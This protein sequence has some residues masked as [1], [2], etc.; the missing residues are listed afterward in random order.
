MHEALTG[1][2]AAL[3]LALLHFLWQG[4]VVGAVAL[5]ALWKLKGAGPQA[6]YAVAC[7]ALL[8]CLLMV[9][10]T[11]GG[12]LMPSQPQG[13][14]DT[15]DRAA[16]V[17]FR[18]APAALRVLAPADT[19][20][21]P[22]LVA[23]WAAGSGVMFLRLALGLASIRR[24]HQHPPA[25]RE[26]QARLDDLAARLGLGPVALVLPD[27]FGSPLSAGWWR[28]IVLLPMGL[29]TRLPVD[30]VEALLAHELAHIRRH[31]YL[32][33]LIQVTIEA[34][35]FYH[36]VVWWLSRQV[37]LEREH[38]ADQLAVRV[39]ASP[40]TL[41]LA[42][43][44]LAD[45]Q[46]PGTA[47]FGTG[48][49]G[50]G[51]L[52]AGLAQAG[53]GGRLKKRI[54]L[55]LRPRQ[56]APRPASALLPLL[57]LTI[58][59]LGLL[60]C[61]AVARSTPDLAPT[62]AAAASP[63][64]SYALVRADALPILA[65]GP[66]DEIDQVARALPRRSGDFV[67]VRR[68]GRDALVTETASVAPLRRAWEHAEALAAEAAALEETL[69]AQHQRAQQLA[70]QT[71]AAPDAN[72]A[73]A[74]DRAESDLSRLQARLDELGRAQEAAYRRV[75]RHLRDV[76]ATAPSVAL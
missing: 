76:L 26:W 48:L 71:E 69:L 41:A 25:P 63:R 35:L 43:A 6:R 34:L 4:V 18:I 65:W 73:A 16:Q 59:A 15:S 13:S 33:N 75:E 23:A 62:E 36:P 24:L 29:V 52:G 11:L 8:A 66:D 45:L 28:P 9:A 54:E 2:V 60:A 21:A 7:T 72:V 58:S 51:S 31:D 67:L 70:E 64:L 74:L 47:P 55:L 56:R 38:I 14:V 12:A 3:C 49:L 42:L 32:V 44:T 37:R 10:V 5:L 1:L 53:S 20:L 61:T 22:W 57:G 39:T 50:T 27:G 19:D 30:H 46:A 40:R 17:G 68:N